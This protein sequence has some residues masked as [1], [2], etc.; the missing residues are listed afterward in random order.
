MCGFFSTFF[1]LIFFPVSFFR[2]FF[3]FSFLFVC[4]NAGCRPHRAVYDAGKFVIH[5]NPRLQDNSRWPRGEFWDKRFL[6]RKSSA[7]NQTVLRIDWPSCAYAL[8]VI[9]SN[10]CASEAS[11][12]KMLHCINSINITLIFILGK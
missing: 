11:T 6:R 1:F 5:F 12:D 3:S 7:P 10:L 9:I 2:F 8:S 4:S